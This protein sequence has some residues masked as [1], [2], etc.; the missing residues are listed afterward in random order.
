MK[1]HTTAIANVVQIK[2]KALNPRQAANYLGISR[3]LL[4]DYLDIRGGPIASIEI[5]K[6][7]Y[8]RG[9]RLVSLEEL[10]KFI[11]GQSG[12]GKSCK[13]N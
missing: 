9:K 2:P 5:R 1:S 13:L 7:G 12:G 4:Y 11:E 8:L 10:D 3:S 6:K